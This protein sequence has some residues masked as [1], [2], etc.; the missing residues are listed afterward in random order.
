M[1]RLGTWYCRRGWPG[2][3]KFE[4]TFCW[5]PARRR[6][7][8][9]PRHG[10]PC[11]DRALCGRAVWC[12]TAVACGGALLDAKPASR[13][14]A[15]ALPGCLAAWL[16]GGLVDTK[17][18]AE[19]LTA[20][21]LGRPTNYHKG[22]LLVRHSSCPSIDLLPLVGRPIAG[23]GPRVHGRLDKVERGRNGLTEQ[24]TT[25]E[26][27]ARVEWIPW[28]AIGCHWIG[29]HVGS[30]ESLSEPTPAFVSHPIAHSAHPEPQPRTK[31]ELLP[32]GRDSAISTDCLPAF[33][34]AAC[35]L[36]ICETPVFSW[37]SL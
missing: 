5:A 36:P 23:L 32:G 10:T 6:P 35:S 4:L 14:G 34:E 17:G 31:R 27:R 30:G 16:A 21:R 20:P 13:S 9:V 24:C 7:F 3:L 12:A 1:V 25:R 33:L 11:S 37:P 15:A 19:L 26:L 8:A 18:R 22:S 2:H 29:E 28:D